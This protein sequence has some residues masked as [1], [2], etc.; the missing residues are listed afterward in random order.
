MLHKL[1]SLQS[2]HCYIL[3]KFPKG[4]KAKTLAQGFAHIFWLTANGLHWGGE[5]REFVSATLGGV[6]G[7]NE[8]KTE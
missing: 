3:G 8:G 7:T 2:F 5:V 4:K 1:F 6:W